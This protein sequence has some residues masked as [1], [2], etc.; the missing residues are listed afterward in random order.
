MKNK[1]LFLI[2]IVIS[3]FLIPFSYSICNQT[4]IDINSANIS[5][6]DKIIN[7]GPTIAQRIIDSRF[8]SSVD[9]L[10]KVSGI[11]NITLEE[12][13]QQ[14]LACVNEVN[15]GKIEDGPEIISDESII[16]EESKE[17]LDEKIVDS[18]NEGSISNI[19][20][21]N[22]EIISFNP[23]PLTLINNNSNEDTKNIK[24]EENNKKL[25][26]NLPLLGIITIILFMIALILLKEFKDRKNEFK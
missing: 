12:I 1:E 5:E 16:K 23:E 17:N 25:Q 26:N 10:I 9:E 7:V 15:E 6:L 11:G 24:S 2:L 13:K 21:E 8:F 3:F 18:K 19:S 14:G 20:Q 22:E 4:Q